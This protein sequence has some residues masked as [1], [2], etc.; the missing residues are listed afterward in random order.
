MQVLDRRELKKQKEV[1]PSF[2]A[3]Q[4]PVPVFNN[5]LVRLHKPKQEEV[6]GGILIPDSA[7]K[8]PNRGEVVAISEFYI[9]GGV[10]HKISDMVEV[11]DE[12]TISQIEHEPV[13]YQGEVLEIVNIWTLKFIHKKKPE[14]ANN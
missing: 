11:G 5:I 9:L 7:R 6:Q 4:K 1:T 3:F 14:N 13:E 8:D 10:K 2:D 12:V